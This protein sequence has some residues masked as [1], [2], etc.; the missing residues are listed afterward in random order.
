MNKLLKISFILLAF[1]AFS[2][3]CSYADNADDYGII[4][5]P[6]QEEEP[7]Q[8]QMQDEDSEQTVSQDDGAIEL[9]MSKVKT[10]KVSNKVSKENLNSE[11][12]Y[13]SDNVQQQ[14]MNLYD[15]DRAYQKKTTSYKR[16]KKFKKG[17]VGAKYDTTFTPDSAT[18]TRTLY[19]NYNLNS[20]TSVNASY[21]N[22]SLA[23]PSQQMKGTISVAPEYRINKKLSVQNKFS[24]NLNSGSTKEEVSVKINPFKD[25]DR[26]DFSVGAGQVQYTNGAPSSSQINFGTNIK[27]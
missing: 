9:D 23:A 5:P 12:S 11:T 3:P 26:M 6:E 4:V 16:E 20:K 25:A 14:N 24:K 1:G 15:T 13:S 27:F 22:D 21:S 7:V 17:N 8:L 10:K 18:Q 2:I 19:S